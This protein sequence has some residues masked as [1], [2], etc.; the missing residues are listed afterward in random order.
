MVK[1]LCRTRPNERFVYLEYPMIMY[2]PRCLQLIWVG[3]LGAEVLRLC[4]F[5]NRRFYMMYPLS[6]ETLVKALT[7][8]P[9]SDVETGNNV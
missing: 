6:L 7:L 8:S 9:T 2:P 1:Y 5:G 4:I 3:S